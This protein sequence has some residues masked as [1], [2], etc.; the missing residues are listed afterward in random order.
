V[1]GTDF[2]FGSKFVGAIKNGWDNLLLFI[3]GSMNLW[4]FLILIGSGAWLFFRWRKKR[5]LSS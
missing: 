4:P 1:L 5:K 2:G 3:V